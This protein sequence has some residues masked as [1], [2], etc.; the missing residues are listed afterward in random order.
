MDAEREEAGD[1][2]A[3]TTL[4]LAPKWAQAVREAE[5]RK[6]RTRVKSEFEMRMSQLQ[7]ER[8]LFKR[9]PAVGD[10]KVVELRWGRKSVDEEGGDYRDCYRHRHCHFQSSNR[11]LVPSLIACTYVWV[12]WRF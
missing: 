11:L 10:G 5:R 1:E 9:L 8:N 6:T 3:M 4:T 2:G 7:P 12:Q